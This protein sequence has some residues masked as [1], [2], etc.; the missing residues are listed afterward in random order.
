[1]S[2]VKITFLASIV[3]FNFLLVNGQ[4]LKRKTRMRNEM[5]EE[6][7][8]LKENKDVKHGSSLTTY[9]YGPMNYKFLVAY[10]E[11]YNNKKTGCWMHFYYKH[12]SNFLK[13]K[14]SFLDDK[15]NG[16]WRYYY[17]PDYSNNKMSGLI[18][19]EQRTAVLKSKRDENKFNIVIDSTGE[20]I[21][22]EGL[23][24]NDMKVGIWK[25]YSQS[26]FLFHAYNHT[27]EELIQN[28]LRIPD[29]DFLV[30]LGGPGRFLNYYYTLQEE[31]T[32]ESPISKS[33][34]VIYEIDKQGNYKLISATGDKKY[35]SKVFEILKEI[36][37]EWIFLKA[38]SVKKLQIVS[39]VI[40]DNDS[41]VR[42]RFNLEFRVVE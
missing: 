4:E 38:E 40:V 12:P 9:F 3:L 30:Y 18:G 17:P 34:E 32:K 14:G 24:Q 41:F 20:Q 37:N 11:Y 1:M 35:K 23:Y 36:P 2:N 15:K 5:I 29:N 16:Y 31:S 21:I 19:N 39:S 28:N 25:Y 27:T 7:F 42:N 6:F 10:G 13:S 26:G 8:V 22:C 33:S